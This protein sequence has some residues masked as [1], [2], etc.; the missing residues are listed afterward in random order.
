MPEREKRVRLYLVDDH[1]LFR[2]SLARFLE[3]E[4]FEVAGGSSTIEEGREFLRRHSFDLLLLDF[5]L[6][7]SDGLDFMRMLDAAGYRGKVLLVTAG[8]NELNTASLIKNGISGVFLKHNPPALLLEAIRNVLAG[9]VWFHQDHLKKV[10]ESSG[11]LGQEPTQGK[12]FTERERQVLTG[13]F[14]GLANKQIADQLQVSESSVKGTL[15][16]LFEK[17][18][19]RTR[20]QLVRVALEQYRDQL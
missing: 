7:Q 6:G 10:V 4:G 9:N 5:N 12:K 16:Q 17:T 20:S 19:V 1:V 3:E 8:V 13:I 18:G 2:E 11:T 15:Q 14:E